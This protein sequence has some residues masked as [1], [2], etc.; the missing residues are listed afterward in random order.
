[1]I[2]NTTTTG[3]ILDVQ[4]HGTIVI[5]YLDAEEHRVVP[6]YFD[7]RPFGWLLDGEGCGAEELIGRTA[8]YDGESLFFD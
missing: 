8:I 7:H 6:I 5:V 1:M 3:T 4:D 2:Q